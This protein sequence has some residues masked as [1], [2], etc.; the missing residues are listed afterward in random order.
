MVGAAERSGGMCLRAGHRTGG[1]GG[2]D[3]APPRA[4]ATRRGHVGGGE[5]RSDRVSGPE[6]ERERVEG[7]SLRGVQRKLRVARVCGDTVY[8]IATVAPTSIR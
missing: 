6:G 3:D 2:R 5:R 7:G 1:G 8:G 4:A